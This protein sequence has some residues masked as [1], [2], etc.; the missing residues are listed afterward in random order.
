MTAHETAQ[1]IADI[2]L[3]ALKVIGAVVSAILWVAIIL[4][5]VFAVVSGCSRPSEPE[6]DCTYYPEYDRWIGRDCGREEDESSSD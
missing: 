5:I 6:Y 4:L 3:S 1:C 2:F